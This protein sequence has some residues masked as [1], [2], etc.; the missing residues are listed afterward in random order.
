MAIL[1]EENIELTKKFDTIDW[2][3]IAQARDLALEMKKI[4]QE[5]K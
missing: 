4:D 3:S 2:D 1:R 5:I